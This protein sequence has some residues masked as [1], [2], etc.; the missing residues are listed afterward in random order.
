LT[1]NEL[2]IN[3]KNTTLKTKLLSFIII[4]IALLSVFDCKCQNKTITATLRIIDGNDSILNPFLLPDSSVFDLKLCVEHFGYPPK[5][6]SNIYWRLPDT[7]GFTNLEKQNIVITYQFD[8]EGKL[9]MYYYQG[10]LISG[11]YPL[12]YFFIY[13]KDNST[14]INEI[15]DYFDN[16]KYKIMY[17]NSKNIRCIEK[18]DSLDKRI[19]ILTINVQ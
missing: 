8:N 2:R 11:V 3:L 10:S 16:T 4:L 12:P 14:L 15:N 6:P 1:I 17:D 19:E 18:Y 9:S 7:T 13:D 5:I